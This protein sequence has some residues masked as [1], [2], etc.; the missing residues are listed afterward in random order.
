MSLVGSAFGPSSESTVVFTFSGVHSQREATEKA[1]VLAKSKIMR[2]F[3]LHE[4]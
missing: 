1:T 2:G 3:W 4:R